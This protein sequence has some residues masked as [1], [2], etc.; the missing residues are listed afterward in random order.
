MRK[1]WYILILVLLLGVGGL[2]WGTHS[3]QEQF[4]EYT[5]T[6]EPIK[7][8]LSVSGN[9]NADRRADLS[10]QT[11][12]RLSWVGVAEGQRVRKWQALASLDQRSVEKTIK[13]D[14]NTYLATRSDF[15]TTR[16]SN[17]VT[18]DNLD[19]YTLS[20]AARR[21]LE[22]SQYDLNNSVLDVEIQSVAKE[23]A[24]VVAPFDG[25]VTTLALANPGVNVLAT[26]PLATVIDP[27][28]LYFQAQ[29]D[30][31]DLAKVRVGATVEL[32]LDAYPDDPISSTV[33]S[34][35]FS[36]VALSGGGT[37][38]NVRIG[39]PSQTEDL[40]YKFGMNGTAV[41][42]V[43]ES[44]D[45]LTLP[46][47]AVSQTSGRSTVLIRNGKSVEEKNITTRLESSD[48]IEIT[49]GLSEGDK[50][51]VRVKK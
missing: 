1:R 31:V 23:F 43:Q 11:G 25:I 30:E 29:V 14:L 28:S 45:A 39:I 37:G 15:Q 46:I 13:K 5:V 41:V 19:Q 38:Y 34:I 21:V 9:L 3:K 32:I 49:G 6:R 2:W 36:P 33:S 18:T 7:V 44:N 16:E 12:G 50:V 4:K 51:V 24:T 40:K 17:N 48:A 26:T 8:T 47:A 10:F 27:T 35:G 22:K 20:T 42:T